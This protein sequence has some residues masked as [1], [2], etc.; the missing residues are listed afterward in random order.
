MVLSRERILD[1]LARLFFIDAG[2]LALILGEPLA[3][4]TV[5]LTPFRDDGAPVTIPRTELQ[6]AHESLILR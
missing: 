4:P 1:T 2:E 3:R 6:S 5:R